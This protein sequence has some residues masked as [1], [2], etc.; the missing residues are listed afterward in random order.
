MTEADSQ[1]KKQPGERTAQFMWT[2]FILGFFMIQA[3]IWTVAITLTSGDK[4][5]AVVASYDERAL[6]WDEEVKRRN[7][8]EKLGWNFNLL[9]D[10]N[11][12][13][14]KRHAVT[15]KLT[16]ADA[17]PVEG[18]TLELKTFHRGQAGDPQNVSFEEIAAGTY[19]SQIQIDKAGL[20]QFEALA[21]V[22]DKQFFIND[23]QYLGSKV[24]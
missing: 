2:V 1:S 5:H 22:G 7:E 11:G 14:K 3:V 12:D 21:S 6:N 15:L 8:S 23:Q 9:V 18:A 10:P 19:K 20:W 13:I 17:N 4:S 24:H 16:D